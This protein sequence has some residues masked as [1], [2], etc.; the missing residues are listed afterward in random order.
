MTEDWIY[1]PAHDLGLSVHD[2]SRCLTR[3]CGLIETGCHFLWGLLTRAYLRGWHRLTIHGREHLPTRPSFVLVANH[4]SHLDALVLTAPLPLTIRDRVFPLAAGDVFF[5]KKATS[6]FAMSLL[7]A[8][9]LWRRKCTPHALTELR[10]K[11][12]E[13]PCGYV[14]FPEG[15]RSR[16]GAMQPFKPGVGMLLAGLDVPVIPCHIDGTF[17]A[18]P[19]ARCVPRPWKITV[20]V[21]AAAAVRSPP[22]HAVRVGRDGPPL[23]RGGPPAGRIGRWRLSNECRPN[24]R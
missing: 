5:E 9:P 18:L 1:D 24:T 7:N 10:T 17:A 14:L 23:C 4:A 21:G 16:D 6:M 11:L 2:R 15:C 3:E 20:R 8:L 13:E 12:V 19:A 22:Q